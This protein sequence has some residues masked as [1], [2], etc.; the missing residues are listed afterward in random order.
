M[1]I[2]WWFRDFKVIVKDLHHQENNE[3]AGLIFKIKNGGKG[4]PWQDR[5]R[6]L[7]IKNMTQ[8]TLKKWLFKVDHFNVTRNLK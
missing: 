8:K 4:C 7:R 5:K 2:N 1:G 3:I 6:L